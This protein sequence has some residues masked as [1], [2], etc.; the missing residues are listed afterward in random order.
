MKMKLTHLISD[1][2]HAP[3]YRLYENEAVS[4]KYIIRECHMKNDMFK[5]QLVGTVSAMDITPDMRRKVLSELAEDKLVFLYESL[6]FEPIYDSMITYVKDLHVITG[7]PYK[8]AYYWDMHIYIP[9]DE[10]HKQ[11]Q[12]K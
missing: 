7:L 11:N 6:L 8:V 9:S 4:I 3:M 10:V 1:L 12:I 2:I 5:Y